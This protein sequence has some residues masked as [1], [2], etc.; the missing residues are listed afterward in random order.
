MYA[1]FSGSS[2]K[3]DK[4]TFNHVKTINI[5]IVHDLKPNLNTFDPTL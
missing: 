1:K 3:Q 5:Y 4:I 2:L